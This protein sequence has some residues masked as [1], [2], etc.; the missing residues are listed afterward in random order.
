MTG[1]P[2]SQLNPYFNLEDANIIFDELK[3]LLVELDVDPL[4]LGP[5]HLNQKVADVRRMLDRC[6][7]IFLDISQRLH[8]C[9]RNLKVETLSLNMKRKNLFAND[10]ETRAGR[11]LSDREAV[12]AGKLQKEIQAVHDL[13]MAVDDLESVLSVIKTKKADLKDTQG[14][15]RDQIRL[16]QEELGLGAR[17]GSKINGTAIPLTPGIANPQDLNELTSILSGIEG[18]IELQK[19]D[20]NWQEPE[21]DKKE[22]A[23]QET[24]PDE[25][26]DAAPNVPSIKV[27]S[28][29]QA[30]S[31]QIDVDAF[32]NIDITDVSEKKSKVNLD[33]DALGN[34][35]S[36]FEKP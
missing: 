11:S 24:K 30:T 26:F 13:E 34:I 16:C 7:R 20:G 31:S 36:A 18:E 9:R 35:L 28:L 6:G 10:P 14:R 33:D 17:W 29:L 12:A 15:L 23:V 1:Q 4:S 22:K 3:I 2:Q 27:E 5:K 21:P 19:L 8:E 25:I 32:L